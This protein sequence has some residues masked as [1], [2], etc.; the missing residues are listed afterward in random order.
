MAQ[1][2]AAG[3]E[4]EVGVIRQVNNRLA[5]G[6]RLV[7]NLQLVFTGQRIRYVR[8]QVSRITLFTIA[9]EIFKA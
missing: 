7:V 6:R 4:V 1:D 2:V 3:G 9:A 5:V 8:R